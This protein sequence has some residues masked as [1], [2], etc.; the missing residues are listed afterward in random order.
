MATVAVPPCDP[1]YATKV[2]RH[3][4][5]AVRYGGCGFEDRVIPEGV[6]VKDEA[7]ILDEDRY[8]SVRVSDRE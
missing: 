1:A 2:D 8:T 4:R 3:R 7:F 5:V 6:V